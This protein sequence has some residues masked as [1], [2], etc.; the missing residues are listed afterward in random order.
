MFSDASVHD[1]ASPNLILSFPPPYD[2]TAG[3]HGNPDLTGVTG[4][5]RALGIQPLVRCM[6]INMAL[7]AAATRSYN[8]IA[9]NALW[10]N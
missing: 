3:F 5:E 7:Y 8:Q 2:I 6:T 10:F 9:N 1:A 4:G